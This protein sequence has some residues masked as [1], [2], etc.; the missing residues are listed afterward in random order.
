MLETG[1]GR[2]MN[3]ALASLPNFSL[4]GDVS[5]SDRFWAR[6]IVTEPIR[7]EDGWVSIPQGPGSGIT[8]DVDWLDSVTTSR[9]ELRP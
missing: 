7:L 3:V 9:V 1:I 5:A 4:P 6:D 2:A 8:I